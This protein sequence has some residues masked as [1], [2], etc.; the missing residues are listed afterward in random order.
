MPRQTGSVSPCLFSWL[1]RPPVLLS[2]QQ[3]LPL[4]WVSGAAAQAE[5]GDDQQPDV[6][7]GGGWRLGGK[8]V[9]GDE[10]RVHA[11]RLPLTQASEGSS[12]QVDNPVGRRLVLLPSRHEGQKEGNT[13]SPKRRKSTRDQS[14]LKKTVAVDENW[15]R[16]FP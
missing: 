3:L 5:G 4:C 1:I 9:P 11:T 7:G 6:I 2:Q 14:G 8:A 10:V 13:P 15:P 16:P 12:F